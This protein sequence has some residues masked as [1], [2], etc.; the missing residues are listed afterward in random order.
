MLSGFVPV[1]DAFVVSRLV[2]SGCSVVAK[3]NLDEFGM[4]SRGEHSAYGPTGN[5]VDP[6]RVVGGS[7]SGSAS[8]VAAGAV[9]VALGSDTGGSV[10]LPASYCG[11]VGFKPSWGALSRR[12]LIAYGS[13]LDVVGVLSRDV[14]DAAL[15]FAAMAGTDGDPL[16][17]TNTLR[18]FEKDGSDVLRGLETLRPSV[19]SLLSS[20]GASTASDA[21]DAL[22]GVSVAEAQRVLANLAENAVAHLPL[23]GQRVCVVREAVGDLDAFFQHAPLLAREEGGASKSGALPPSSSS[24]SSSSSSTSSALSSSETSASLGRSAAALSALG[25]EVS[26]ASLPTLSDALPAYYVIACA[27]ASANLNRYDG[28]RYG[29][30]DVEASELVALQARSRAAGL[31]PAVVRRILAGAHALSAGSYEALYARAV[32]VRALV[33]REH[34]AIFEAQAPKRGDRDDAATE[35]PDDARSTGPPSVGPFASRSPLL[36]LPAAPG[37]APPRGA[38]PDPLDEVA[39]DALTVPASLAGLPAIALPAVDGAPGAGRVGIQ[40]VGA[41][42]TDAALLRAAIAYD[43]MRRA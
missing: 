38:D 33:A 41:R 35:N 10:R 1:R 21:V 39:A 27:E 29:A 14:P 3:A 37:P 32:D 11:I 12:G 15:A 20:L 22:R 19:S 6:S 26:F 36:L 30:R 28:V 43:A 2:E 17:A 42:G 24:S 9:P 25:A 13:S 40:L 5:P 34:D 4:G 16:D 31:G 18:V 23:L 8:L 7:S